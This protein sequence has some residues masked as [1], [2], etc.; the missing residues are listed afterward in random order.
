MGCKVVS[1]LVHH[2]PMCGSRT[3]VMVPFMVQRLTLLSRTH[4]NVGTSVRQY[5]SISTCLIDLVSN[6]HCLPRQQKSK[7]K[8]TMYSQI[9]MHI[10]RLRV[11]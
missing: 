2:M 5:S 9:K 3:P 11:N 7:P 8:V 10:T 6:T 1:D 4:S